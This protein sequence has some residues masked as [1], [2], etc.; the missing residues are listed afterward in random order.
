MTVDESDAIAIL[1]D[2]GG[3]GDRSITFESA[4]WLVAFTMLIGA[5]VGG[6]LVHGMQGRR[7]HSSAGAPATVVR[8][9]VVR[10]PAIT[11]TAIARKTLYVRKTITRSPSATHNTSVRS[12][13]AGGAVLSTLNALRAHDFE[14]PSGLRAK[15]RACARSNART[16]RQQTCAS[17]AWSAVLSGDGLSDSTFA[18]A[19]IDQP[20]AA[21]RSKQYRKAA[22]TSATA[23]DGRVFWVLLLS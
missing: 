16:S 21:W 17:A 14:T 15:A 18:K 10:T 8:Q 23:K 2:D 9:L 13:S 4:A 6:L 19:I 5:A 3:N 20:D 7:S 12:A 22:A 1:D 11:R